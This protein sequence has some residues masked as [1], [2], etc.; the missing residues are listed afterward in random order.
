MKSHPIRMAFL[1]QCLFL[2]K[3]PH[4]YRK[5]LIRSLLFT[6]GLKL[7]LV[8]FGNLLPNGWQ[9][10]DHIFD[11][12]ARND[13]GWYHQIARDWYPKNIVSGS[14]VPDFAFFPLYPFL[15]RILLNVTHDYIPAALILHILTTILWVAVLYK[16]LVKS[17]F[18]PSKAFVFILL[19]QCF[20]YHYIFHAFYSEQLFSILLLWA[21]IEIKGNR[22]YFLFLATFLLSLCRPTGLVMA[23]GMA[24]I[25]L[26]ENKWL[27]IFSNAR[28][29]KMVFALS[30]AFFG[31]CAWS[32]YLKYYC[33][34]PFAFSNA[35][36]NWGRHY[37]WPWESFFANGKWDNQLLSAYVL[38]LLILA[39]FAMRKSTKGRMLFVGINT[40]FPLI[41]GSVLSM[42]RFFAVN[43]IAFES[44][45]EWF[46]KRYILWAAFLLAVNLLTYYYWVTFSG[47]LSY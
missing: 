35:Q 25:L 10:W 38:L 37:C 2:P 30:G 19:Y 21:L 1:F 36:A 15:I 24:F 11:V 46:Y 40:I 33:G 5:Y 7:V 8:V 16:Y 3:M 12:L 39:F 47:W 23:I 31:V 27:K 44:I 14:I 28:K 34:D 41:T 43:V 22:W 20:P 6:F 17:N 45:F 26:D 13:S 9:G 4:D 42:Q 32:I 29:L 18:Q